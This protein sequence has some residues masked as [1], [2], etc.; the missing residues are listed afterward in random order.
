MA[1][2]P[3]AKEFVPPRRFG[4]PSGVSGLSGLKISSD[5]NNDIENEDDSPMV[6]QKQNARV[7]NLRG[8]V[9]VVAT[10]EEQQIPAKPPRAPTVV[11]APWQKK[12]TPPTGEMEFDELFSQSPSNTPNNSASLV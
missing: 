6:D 7:R 5:N 9:D 10:V 8:A 1:L 2:N 3:F 4:A 12:S 11:H